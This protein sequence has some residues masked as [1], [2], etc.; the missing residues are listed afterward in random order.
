MPRTTVEIPARELTELR[1]L[2]ARRGMHGFSKLVTDAVRE[3]L[4]RRDEAAEEESLERFRS[5]R[6][7]LRGKPAEEL[8]AHVR[9]LRSERW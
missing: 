6:G 9:R 8:R 2:A 4:R 7:A 3:Y 5:A 1:A